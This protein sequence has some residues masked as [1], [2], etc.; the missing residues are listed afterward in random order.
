VS[1]KQHEIDQDLAKTYGQ[2][3][4]FEGRRSAGMKVGGRRHWHYDK[5]EWK[6][7][8]VAPDRWEFSYAVPKRRAGHAPPGSGDPAGT[9]VHWYILAH[10][11]V[12]KLDLNTYATAMSGL[13]VKLAH[14]RAGSG[15]W[16][17]SDS[18]QRLRLIQVLQELIDELSREPEPAEPG[19]ERAV[20]AAKRRPVRPVHS[21]LGT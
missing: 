14:R 4:T 15:S 10:Q 20:G 16:S 17:A 21:I 11:N 8:Q 12:R 3:R 19:V 9:E 7:I 18:A 6:E 13:K 2:F 5:G 1:S